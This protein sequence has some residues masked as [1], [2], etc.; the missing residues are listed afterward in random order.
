MLSHD[1]RR[2]G[3]WGIPSRGK[4]QRNPRALTHR[5]R[6]KWYRIIGGSSSEK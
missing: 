3:R 5:A 4:T 2:K 1:P 6:L